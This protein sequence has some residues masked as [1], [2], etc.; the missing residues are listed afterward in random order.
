LPLVLAGNENIEAA[1]EQHARIFGFTPVH[2]GD[3]SW[4]WNADDSELVSST[5]ASLW[6]NHQPDFDPEDSQTGIFKAI[7]RADFAM[8]FEEDGLRT[9]VSWQV[10]E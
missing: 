2:P 8:Q 10:K 9:T 6:T 7:A 3:G 4:S 5:Y 1:R